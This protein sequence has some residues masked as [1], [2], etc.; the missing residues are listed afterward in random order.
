MSHSWAVKDCWI[1]IV[2]FFQKDSVI[3][4]EKLGSP[5]IFHPVVKGKLDKHPNLVSYNKNAQKID[6]RYIWRY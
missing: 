3:K 2:K 1:M 4:P 5:M 6:C